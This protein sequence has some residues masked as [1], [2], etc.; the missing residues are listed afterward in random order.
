[1]LLVHLWQ[2]GGKKMAEKKKKYMVCLL[3]YIEAEDKDKCQGQI[4]QLNGQLWK[5]REKYGLLRMNTVATQG[6]TDELIFG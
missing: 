2:P 4:N 5:D 6:I 1:M 3:L